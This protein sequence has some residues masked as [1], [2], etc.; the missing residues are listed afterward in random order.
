M[1]DETYIETQLQML[2][3]STKTYGK[4]WSGYVLAG[5]VML[6]RDASV[7]GEEFIA[8]VGH[9]M[10][11]SDFPMPS[12]FVRW[13][14]ENRVSAE[15]QALLIEAQRMSELERGFPHPVLTEGEPSSEAV[16]ARDE[17]LRKMSALPAR[18]AMPKPDRT[19]PKPIEVD[20]QEVERNRAQIA[21]GREGVGD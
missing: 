6:M 15:T 12:E 13:I 7:K 9:F 18:T 2:H 21:A 16:A 19:P 20:E 11:A 1:I 10:A 8:A 4:P 17:F 14:R 5:F 3:A